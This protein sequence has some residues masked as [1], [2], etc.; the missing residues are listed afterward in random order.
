MHPML[1]SKCL[2]ISDNLLGLNDRES[3]LVDRMKDV[4]NQN[5][6]LRRQLSISQNQLISATSKVS[7]AEN[8]GRRLSSKDDNNNSQQNVV[9]ND[10]S[11]DGLG[12]GNN[13]GRS[14]KVSGCRG[15]VGIK[16]GTH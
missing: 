4:E 16:L 7:K 1:T 9:N 11:E 12:N 14:E 6:I 5:R 13:E 3:R 10:A 2:H 15:G 8:R